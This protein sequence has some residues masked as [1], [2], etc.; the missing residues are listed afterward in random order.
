MAIRGS[1]PQRREFITIAMRGQQK[2]LEL[3]AEAQFPNSSLGG[4]E[5]R[6][7]FSFTAEHAAEKT[8]ADPVWIPLAE[9]GAGRCAGA[10][11]HTSAGV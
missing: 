6:K 3:P 10:H 9:P 4:L 11:P 7:Y 8:G 1:P 2:V 5:F